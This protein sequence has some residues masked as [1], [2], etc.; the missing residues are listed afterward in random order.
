M[1][2]NPLP[3]ASSRMQWMDIT[4]EF[5]NLTGQL[6][7]GKVVQM[8]NFRL[9]DAMTAVELMDPKMDANGLILTTSQYV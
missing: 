8:P 7:L 3:I 2:L 1:S 6:S 4:E 9:F 5:T